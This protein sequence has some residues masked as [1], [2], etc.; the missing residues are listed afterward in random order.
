MVAPALA[1]ASCCYS[2]FTV[3][4]STCRRRRGRGGGAAHQHSFMMAGA[5]PLLGARRARG[6]TRAFAASMHRRARACVLAPLCICYI[7]LAST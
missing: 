4:T 7:A 3:Q 5:A 1:A 6:K 2:V